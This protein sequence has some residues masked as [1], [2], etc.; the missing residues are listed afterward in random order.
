VNVGHVYYL[1][2]ISTR[3]L[4]SLA[5]GVTVNTP[6]GAC[7]MPCQAM[8][9]VVVHVA[10]GTR[11]ILVFWAAWPRLWA[12]PYSMPVT[13]TPVR[14]IPMRCTSREMHTYDVHARKM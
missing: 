6:G 5:Y 14:G 9:V 3:F 4:R 11:D 12:T 13:Y 7:V 1:D 2:F 10:S 8:S